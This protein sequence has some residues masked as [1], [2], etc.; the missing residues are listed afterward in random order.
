MQ[1]AALGKE[2]SREQ[3]IAYAAERG[4]LISAAQLARWHRAGLLPR[5]RRLHL[6]RGKGTQSV[7]PV[8]AAPQ[9]L[10]L[11]LS[12]R[13]HRGLDAMAWYTWLQGFPLTERIRASLL[14]MLND[15]IALL[16][17]SLLDMTSGDGYADLDEEE[18]GSASRPDADALHRTPRGF[19]RVKRRSLSTVQLA[20]SEVL[21]GRLEE[22][23]AFDDA[24]WK[25]LAQAFIPDK[26][27]RTMGAPDLPHI[28]ASIS[29]EQ[30]FPRIR[31]AIA[32]MSAARLEATRDDAL[33]LW[34]Y[35]G[36]S[37]RP[38]PE[39]TP[40]VFIRF[41]GAVRVSPNGRSVW[42]WYR[43]TLRNAGFLTVQEAIAKLG[44]SAHE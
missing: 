22:Y 23:R 35:L 8:V 28:L 13:R 21:L 11:A 39:P 27:L 33:L 42:L 7:Y 29:Q 20:L 25:I 18:T 4:I 31:D 30:S 40:E 14:E 2:I 19:G 3:V 43:R 41:L 9:A 32:R 1:Q 6:G 24:D 37:D 36:S 17:A 26:K 44:N 34:S 15:G 38:L 12:S 16:E 10:G 5:P